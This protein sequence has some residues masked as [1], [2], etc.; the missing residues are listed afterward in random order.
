MGAKVYIGLG[1]NLGDR[2]RQLVLARDALTRVEGI[3]LLR[4][5]SLYESA[6]VGPPQPRYLNAVV[7]LDCPIGLQVL[8]SALQRIELQLG[9]ERG[10]RWGPR[11]IDLDILLWDGEAMDDS[12]LCVPHPELH[13]RRFALEPLAELVPT[14]R[15]P[16]LGESI[17]E[18]LERVL[19]QDVGKWPGSQWLE[20]PRRRSA[21]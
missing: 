9:R 16:V 11:A 15:H 6:P 18:L 8:L 19:D 5:S 7:E 14:A 2:E 20:L 3:H 1:S 17:D 21:S 4:S 12:N 13:N 10:Q